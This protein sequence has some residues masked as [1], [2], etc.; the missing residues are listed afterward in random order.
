MTQDLHPD[1]ADLTPEQRELL[2]LRL[3]RA[4]ADRPDPAAPRPLSFT[5]EQ[6]WFLDRLEPGTPVYNVPFAER[7]TGPLDVPALHR[8]VGAVVARH[9]AL[10]IVFAEADG[11]VTQR[12]RDAPEVPLPVVDLRALPAAERR[13]AADRE[14][15]AHAAVRFDLTAGPLLAVRLLALADDEHLLLVTVH[16][17]IFDAWSAGLFRDELVRWYG[18]FA[19]GVPAEVP[20]LPVRFVDHVAA[21]RQP[22]AERALAGHLGHWRERLAGAPARSTLPPDRPRPPVQTHRGRSLPF[23]VDAEATGALDGL[24]RG[25]GATVNAVALAGLA[26]LLHRATGQDDVL[27]GMPAAGRG[28]TELE[29]LIGCFA[30]MLVLRV[31]VAGD[32]T[33]RD[34]VRR[35]H[36]TVSEA[37]AHQEAP[38]ARVVEEVRPPRDPSV[39]P[40]FQVLATMT[41]GGGDERQAA[42]A[43]FAPVAAENGLTDFDLFVSLTRRGDRIE[44]AVDFNADLYL[45]ETVART[46][47][48]LPEL[49][50]AM[51]AVPD[52]PLSQVAGLGRQRISLAATFTVDPLR[53]PVEFWLRFLRMPAAVE[54]V[55]Y[56]QLVG[57]LLAGA[58]TDA[59]VCLLRWE[60]WLR[61]QDG[62]GGAAA[63]DAAM[64]DLAAAVGAYRRRTAAPLLLVVCPASPAFADRRAAELSGRLD[65]RL[66]VLAARTPGVHA[67]WAAD[68]AG[69]YP[70]SEVSDGRADELGHVPYTTEYFAALGTIVLRELRRAVGQPR[71]LVLVDGERVVADR[72]ADALP[73]HEVRACPAGGLAAALAGT[74]P[75]ATVVLDPEPETV[76]ALRREHPELLALT[77]PGGWD[78]LRRFLAHVWP[79]DPPADDPVPVAGLAPPI[80]PERAV[81]LV[82]ELSTPAAVAER[83]RPAPIRAAGPDDAETVAPRTPTEER[84]AGLWAAALGVER[85]GVTSDFFGLGGHSLLATH[86]LSQVQ[87]EFDREVSLYT[88][89]TNPTVAQLAAMLDADDDGSA[90]APLSP[91]AP[92]TLAVA[93]S[94][95][96]RLWALDQL[97]DDVVRHNTTA[98][99]ELRGHLDEAALRRALDDVVARHELL[100]TTF[101]D[102]GG[103]PEP[104]VH[105]HLDP[106]VEPLDLTDLPAAKQ[107]RALRRAVTGHAAHR[108]DLAAGP[109]LRARLVRL[110]EGRHQLLLGMHHIVCDNTSWSVL[111]ADLAA[112][113]AYHVTGAGGELPPLPAQF[114]DYARH[115]RDWLASPA[116][117]P[118]LAYWRDRL[119][120]APPLLELPT[121]H[122][123]P[124]ERSDVAGYQSQGLPA[125]LGA[126]VRELA[127]AE[128]VTPFAVLLAGFAA[129]LHRESGQ[130][131]LVLGVPTAGRDRAELAPL[132]GCFADLLPLRVD[133][134]G[135]PA[136]RQLVGRA[137]RTAR[138]AYRHQGVPFA[139][140]VEALRLPR[141]TAYHPLF[142][143]VLN[144]IDG[145]DDLPEFPGLAASPVDVPSVG[146][147]F[148]LFLSL[149]WQGEE[150]HADLAYS[151]DL[152]TPDRMVRLLTGLG[153][154]LGEGLRRPDAPVGGARQAAPA[155]RT[156][157]RPAPRLV[158]GGTVALPGLPDTVRFWSE[159]LDLPYAL[160]QLPPGA[161]LRLLR[162][163]AAGLATAARDRNVLLLRWE[164]RVPPGPLGAATV[165][166]RDFLAEL[167]AALDAYRARTAAPLTLL[168][169]PASPRY[170][171]APWEGFFADLTAR[172]RES[173]AGRPGVDVV[174]VEAWAR[175]YRVPELFAGDDWSPELA[176]VTG[177]VLVRRVLRHPA[178]GRLVVP[179]GPADRQAELA[180]LLA[181]QARAGR[182]VLLTAAPQAPGLAALVTAGILRYAPTPPTDAGTLIL[183][184]ATEPGPPDGV[185]LPY[186]PD[187]G[188]PDL[189]RDLWLLDPPT[190]CFGPAIMDGARP[191]WQVDRIPTDLLAEVA[192]ELAD[193]TAV[194]A[195][196]AEG[197]RR[198]ADRAAAAPRTER[199]RRL[200]A[201]W[202]DLLRT[203]K[204]GIHDDFF[205]VG[206]DSLLAMQLV[207][208][209]AEA[210]IDVTPRQLVRY[211]TVAE[212]AASLGETATVDAEQGEV[213]G[214]APLTGAQRWFTDLVAPTMARPALFNHPYYLQLARPLDTD[215]VREAVRRLVAQHDALRLRLSRQ[216]DGSWRQ[217]HADPAEAVPFAGHDLTAVPVAER[218]AAVEALAAEAQTGLDLTAGPLVRVAHFRLGPELA[219]RLLIVAHHLVVDAVSRGVL[220]ADLET[221]CGQLERGEEP[222]LP[223][224]TTSYRSWAGRLAEY[225]GSARLRA[226]LPFWL[227]QADDGV[228]RRLAD[229]PETAPFRLGDLGLASVT[230]DE[231]ATRGLHAAARRLRAS[232]RDLL[233][234][235]V[236]HTVAGRTGGAVTVATTGHGR[237]PLFDDVDV[238]RTTGWFQVLYPLRLELP[239]T[240]DPTRS[241]RSVIRQLGPVPDNGI[242]YG[243]LRYLCPDAEVRGR[244]AATPPPAIAVNYMG[245]FGFDDVSPAN[246]LL[247]V[248]TAPFGPTEDADGH[249]PFPFDVTGSLSGAGLRVDLSYATPA[250]RP[251]TADHLLDGIRTSL[252]RLAGD[253]GQPPRQ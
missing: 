107:A 25:A 186:D 193:A 53:D 17:I 132:V 161:L 32:P 233:V 68:H 75:A 159:L 33:V 94:A 204:L 8:A 230:L 62:A 194:R 203:G 67:V 238:T 118:H 20:A 131:D 220:L 154:V 127:R 215:L 168:V 54:P 170:R 171:T 71:R 22:A 29:P 81:Y 160:G 74:D 57:H 36:R 156:T 166:L 152:F 174:T 110:P 18:E 63:L 155:P 145:A 219:D 3:R 45:D 76:A 122:A 116:V 106:W 88:L 228:L 210:G 214:D 139:T 178:V 95:Q 109:L 129:L 250:F 115:Q 51:A 213:S 225:A 27:L 137:Y 182:A 153:Q 143:C 58:E 82:E 30:N 84:L 55:G 195:A 175:R 2:A 37:Y 232:V 89:F 44:G 126:A 162:D 218:E 98:A 208:R 181:A 23:T 6:L 197:Y 21:R 103:E 64:D 85:V 190:G 135:R 83:S 176:A 60:D 141:Q 169:C 73:G 165:G 91:A 97:G 251:D 185:A 38:Y 144:V 231:A 111:L 34:L 14:I 117:E 72:L 240:A 134:A 138:E 93:S 128:G 216:P 66:A 246:Q 119:R 124:Q 9:D 41:D 121:D 65:D 202:S 48:R 221:L 177:T 12:V 133:V 179:P 46:V 40:L 77:V 236:V 142:Q 147:D 113:Y 80:G 158:V 241:V 188:P 247:D 26:A 149:T 59:T 52:R 184:P 61:R 146:V 70:V 101:R 212:L 227:A 24:A 100:R 112:R 222:A 90:L 164:D 189:L 235:A 120:D 99:V 16:H 223:A 102:G 206:G 47:G 11:M 198:R 86:L 140:I 157:G 79:L 87:A 192:T 205:A 253:H 108:Y 200:V 180:A 207:A 28:S 245:G 96:V 239:T 201:I 226:E 167:A 229:E 151:A 31:D 173:Q 104:V 114:A 56:G 234:W 249:W 10:R 136:F 1:L 35:V 191:D 252:L 172:L 224:K 123:R 13:A 209:C 148:D 19:A 78:E 92:G 196:V 187:A 217:H 244:L 49:L 237:E 243:L 4:R 183:H 211:P 43:T 15:A 199:E 39:N 105:P 163:P 242:G 125:G 42:G 150:L 69:A 50:R 5:Q 248:C 7:I 130:T